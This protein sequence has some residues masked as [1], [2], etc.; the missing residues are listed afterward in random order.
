MRFNAVNDEMLKRYNNHKVWFII[1]SSV[2]L[3]CIVFVIYS[4]NFFIENTSFFIYIIIGI[5]FEI[6]SITSVFLLISGVKIKYAIKEIGKHLIVNINDDCIILEDEFEEKSI[7]IEHCL[8]SIKVTPHCFDVNLHLFL[9]PFK[10]NTGLLI[11]IDE[12]KFFK[13]MSSQYHKRLNPYEQRVAF[14]KS[15]FFVSCSRADSLLITEKL[16]KENI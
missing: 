3:L 15:G 10:N 2:S 7:A 9:N 13:A 16:Q 4:I 8:D 5:I 11:T 14:L 6:S 1:S 12:E